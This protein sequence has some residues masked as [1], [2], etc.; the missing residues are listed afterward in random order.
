MWKL[1]QQL[2]GRLSLQPLQQPADRDLRG[3]RHQQMHVI[4]ADV[5]LHDRH[6]VLAANLADQ[7]PYPQS[8][9]PGQGGSTILGDPYQME[10]N[11]KNRVRPV[12]IL[13]HAAILRE[14]GAHAKAV[15][16]KA[17]ALTLPE[18]DSTV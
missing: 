2:I 9:F 1:P 8:D 16:Y 3:H 17:R 6:F 13:L 14:R 11:L 12:P 18:G 5:A 7:I 10:V 15:A 4:L